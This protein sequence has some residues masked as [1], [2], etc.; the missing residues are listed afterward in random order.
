MRSGKQ[1]L[2]IC[3]LIVLVFNFFNLIFKA[4]WLSAKDLGNYTPPSLLLAL[5]MDCLMSICLFSAF[6]TSGK[7]K[8]K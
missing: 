7:L 1:T 5:S 2:D 8:K 6:Q 4:E 3:A